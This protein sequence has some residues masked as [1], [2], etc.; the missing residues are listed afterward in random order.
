MLKTEGTFPCVGQ[1]IHPRLAPYGHQ[2]SVTFHVD[3]K[4]SLMAIFTR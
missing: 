2:P 4:P 3:L 1:S